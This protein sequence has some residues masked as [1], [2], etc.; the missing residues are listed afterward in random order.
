MLSKKDIFHFLNNLNIEGCVTSQ[1]CKKQKDT[2]FEVETC[3]T[4]GCSWN[5]AAEEL[6]VDVV[7]EGITGRP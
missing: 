6:S 7:T 4:F 3:T 1:G 2:W 5:E